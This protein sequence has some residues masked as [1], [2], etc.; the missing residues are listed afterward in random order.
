MW[1]ITLHICN[2]C[3]NAKFLLIN[4]ARETLSQ[5][6]HVET[7]MCKRIFSRTNYFFPSMDKTNFLT[8]SKVQMSL[9]TVF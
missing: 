4:F 8:Q 1:R 9:K 7:L 5:K 6:T 2:N 3:G